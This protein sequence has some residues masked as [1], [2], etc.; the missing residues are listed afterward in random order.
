MTEQEIADFVERFGNIHPKIQRNFIG[1][2]VNSHNNTRNTYL[3]NSEDRALIILKS[4]G[5]RLDKRGLYRTDLSFNNIPYVLNKTI[6]G[7]SLDAN[8]HGPDHSA[9]IRRMRCTIL[10]AKQDDE[11]IAKKIQKFVKQV[12]TASVIES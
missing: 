2:L 1:L 7:F 10:F 6:S 9:R 5:F 8:I 3:K 4:L 11:K 12:N